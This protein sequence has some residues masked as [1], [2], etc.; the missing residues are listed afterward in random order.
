[1]V[2]VVAIIRRPTLMWR[3]NNVK[4]KTRSCCGIHNFKFVS[5][6]WNWCCSIDLIP[7]FLQP[8]LNFLFWSLH[9][10]QFS[11]LNCFCDTIIHSNHGFTKPAV[12]RRRRRRIGRTGSVTAPRRGKRAALQLLHQ[13]AN[14]VGGGGGH[15][16]RRRVGDIRLR[17][18]GGEGGGLL[19]RGGGSEGGGRWWKGIGGGEW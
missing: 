12:I 19:L 10:I 6:N 3:S 13:E 4:S 14:A 15:R 7:Q 8:K 17:R 11:L 16:G 2:F 5:N 18:E 9:C 1:M